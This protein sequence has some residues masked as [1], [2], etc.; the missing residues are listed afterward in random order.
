MKALKYIQHFIQHRKFTMLDEM[1]DAFAPAL[2]NTKTKQRKVYISIYVYKLWQFQ[3]I[4]IHFSRKKFAKY[5]YYYYFAQLVNSHELDAIYFD[6][7][8]FFHCWKINRVLSFFIS[9]ISLRKFI[10]FRRYLS[11]EL[12]TCSLHINKTWF[13]MDSSWFVLLAQSLY[14]T[15]CNTSAGRIN[16][17][18]KE[19]LTVARHKS[20]KYIH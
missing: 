2:S 3:N 1:L 6:I 7:F 14:K 16:F 12:Y 11:L 18:Q 4:Y 13:L 9:F 5:V 20:Q 10:M 17:L 15:V 19:V 8:L